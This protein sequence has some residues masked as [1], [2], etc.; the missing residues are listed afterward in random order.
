MG[1]LII[2]SVP[3]LLSLSPSIQD[4]RVPPSNFHSLSQVTV[5]LLADNP[6]HGD[7]FFHTVADPEEALMPSTRFAPRTLLGASSPDR[8]MMGHLLGSQIAHA[9]TTK[10]PGETRQLMLGLGLAKAE[11][12]REVFLQIVELVLSV[13]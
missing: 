1:T 6:T 9:I 7:H 4:P 10:E 8:E 13:I 12:E 3:T 5:P 2:V 11:V